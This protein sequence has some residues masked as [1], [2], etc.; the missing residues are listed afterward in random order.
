MWP[1]ELA[2]FPSLVFLFLHLFSLRFSWIESWG[3]KHERKGMKGMERLA[4][5]SRSPS[6]GFW[7][8][9]WGNGKESL[10]QTY[11]PW[12]ALLPSYPSHPFTLLTTI[13]EREGYDVIASSLDSRFHELVKWVAV[14]EGKE[15]TRTR[16]PFP[17]PGCRWPSFLYLFLFSRLYH[18]L[19][20][21]PPLLGINGR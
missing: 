9:V 18:Y 5:L 16:Y 8:Y 15:L 13:G 2:P 21:I 12:Q 20:T 3:W 1:W 11:L 7:S 4:I 6:Y 17:A 10:Y 14:N 19:P